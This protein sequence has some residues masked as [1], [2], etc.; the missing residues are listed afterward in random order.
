M[1][2]ETILSSLD[3]EGKVNL[4]PMGVHLPDTGGNLSAVKEISLFLYPG[5][6]TYKNL[7]AIREGVANLTDDV[8]IFVETALFS[9]S[10]PTLPSCV[11]RP[12]RLAAA[13]AVFEFVVTDFNSSREPAKV[14]GEVRYY[15]KLGGFTGFC[16]A[17]G[18]VL[19]AAIAATRCQWIPLRDMEEDWARWRKIVEK[20]GGIRERAAFKR[21]YDYLML[22]G[23]PI[24]DP[25]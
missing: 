13:R 24:P 10:F 9:V 20:T 22:Q 16:R 1:I 25:D 21:I 5:S 17:Q 11:V 15:E 12:P 18:A 4:A 3:K 23:V 14:T 6:H 19:E 7:S 8:G 2:L